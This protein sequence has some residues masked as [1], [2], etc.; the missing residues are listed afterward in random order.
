M[1]CPVCGRWETGGGHRCPSRVLRAIDAADRKA[2]DDELDYWRREPRRVP[3]ASRLHDGLA[4]M[5][6]EEPAR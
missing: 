2:G 3:V 1:T 6:G 4:L 5:F